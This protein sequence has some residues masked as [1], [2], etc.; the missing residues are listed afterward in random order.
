[1]KAANEAACISLSI[2]ISIYEELI[3]T[4]NSLIPDSINFSTEE[5]G[6]GYSES[7]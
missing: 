1:M 4:E 7:E 2:S 6:T 3:A 5:S